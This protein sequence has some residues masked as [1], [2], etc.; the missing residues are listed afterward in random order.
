MARPAPLLDW[1][2]L[3]EENSAALR[4][5]VD[6]MCV[7]ISEMKTDIRRLNDKMEAVD[8]K[9]A[10]KIDEVDKRLGGRIDEL[11]RRLSGK[12]DELDRRLSGKIDALKDSLATLALS[13]EKSFAALKVSRAM[14]RVWWLLIA[15]A[16]LGVLARGFKWI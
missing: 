8:Q 10:A 11:D 7:D 12:I 9:L 6:H 15:G 5:T 14:D 3:V 4:A 1:E 13:T 16:L 2:T